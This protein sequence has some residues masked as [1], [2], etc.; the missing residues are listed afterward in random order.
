LRIAAISDIHVL[1]NGS[2]IQLLETIRERVEEIG[3]DVFIIAGDIS[4]RLIV[5]EDSL[6]S[7]K[8]EGCKN[9]FVGGN[10]DIWF[11]ED[12]GPSSLEKYSHL[13][14]E[15]CQRSGFQHVP[16][17]PFIQDGFGFVGSIGW[18][19]YSFRREDLEIP[20]ENYQLKEYR[21]AVWYDLFRIDW[22]FTDPEATDLFN[23][24]LEYDLSTLSKS[25]EH[26]VYI[27]HHLPF[28]KLT[29]YKD[30]LPWDLYSAFM[31]S[32]STGEILLTDNRVCLSIS[33]HSHLRSK[34]E[35]GNVVSVT[36]PLGY[37]RPSKNKMLDFVRDAIAFIEISDGRVAVSDFV[38]GDI[39]ADLPY[40]SSR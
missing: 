31:G 20:L 13:L 7:L 36:V 24:K 34:I 38:E 1:P 18:Y 29:V 9:L 39:C 12:G 22:G 16:D 14:G 2:D 27:S 19:D 23:K 21:G 40:F 8:V 26:V 4:D 28:Q 32:T 37:C 17:S 3:P 30:R 10:H 6:K 5:L 35:N 15:I 25:V 33:G 11:E